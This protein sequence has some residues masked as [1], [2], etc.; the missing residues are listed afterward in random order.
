MHFASKSTRE[1]LT[2]ALAYLLRGL[3]HHRECCRDISLEA[4]GEF[5]RFARRNRPARRDH[6]QRFFL[7]C[8][9]ACG[10]HRKNTLLL[11]EISARDAFVKG[12]PSP[13]SRATSA[14]L[15][16]PTLTTVPSAGY[17]CRLRPL[18][19]ERVAVYGVHTRILLPVTQIFTL[20]PATGRR[21]I[22]L[23]TKRNYKRDTNS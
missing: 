19:I 20:S 3:S 5:W 22:S 6:A 1:Q 17:H 14:S 11:D 9:V 7:R 18:S 21:A 15:S 13:L 4:I 12:E 16:I 2:A 8:A 23:F 10:Q